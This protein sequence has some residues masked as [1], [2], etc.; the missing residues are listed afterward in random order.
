MINI[1]DENFYILSIKMND[2]NCSLIKR[3]S[4]KIRVPIINIEGNSRS[5]SKKITFEMEP[6]EYTSEQDSEQYTGYVVKDLTPEQL[7]N[8]LKEAISSGFITAQRKQEHSSGT[9]GN[10]MR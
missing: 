2:I 3:V 5:V 4:T 8:F 7:Y 1:F 10:T 6:Y 9:S